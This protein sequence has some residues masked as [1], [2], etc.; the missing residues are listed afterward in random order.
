MTPHEHPPN[1]YVTKLERTETKTILQRMTQIN[2]ADLFDGI[3]NM[4]LQKAKNFF[5]KGNVINHK[6]THVELVVILH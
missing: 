4:R 2:V 5:A 1:P 6:A 3:S